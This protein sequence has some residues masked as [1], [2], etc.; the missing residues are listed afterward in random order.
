MQAHSGKSKQETSRNKSPQVKA[1]LNQRSDHL[2]TDRLLGRSTTSSYLVAKMKPSWTSE[3]SPSTQSGTKYDL[4]IR[5]QEVRPLQME[6]D[7][8]KRSRAK[9]SRILKSKREI[10]TRIERRAEGKQREMAN[11]MPNTTPREETASVG[12]RKANVHLEKHA[13]SS[14]TRT[15][16]QREGTTSFTFSDGFTAPK[17]ER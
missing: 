9:K 11:K 15:R 12:S 6:V 2:Q 16:K 10:E 3:M 5:R 14:V 4:N 13:H 1:K 17:F 7:V 8:P